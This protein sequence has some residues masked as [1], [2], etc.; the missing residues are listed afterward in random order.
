MPDTTTDTKLSISCVKCGKMFD[1]K[2]RQGDYIAWC[3]GK[4]IQEAMPYLSKG[5]RELLLS[6][7]CNDCFKAIFKCE[8]SGR[9]E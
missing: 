2:I 6:G 7:Y 4:L 9:E 1:L 3:E 8:G 5:E